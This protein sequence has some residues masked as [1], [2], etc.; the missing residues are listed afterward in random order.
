MT[1][2]SLKTGIIHSDTCGAA[3]PTY[4]EPARALNPNPNNVNFVGEPVFG[5]ESGAR[6]FCD[7]LVKVKKGSKLV[8]VLY[9]SG[10]V[11]TFEAGEDVQ[12]FPDPESEGNKIDV[13]NTIIGSLSRFEITTSDSDFGVGERV[14]VADGLGKRATALVSSVESAVGVVDFEIIGDYKGWGYS[15]DAE[16]IGTD[17]ILQADQ[18]VFENTD[19]FYHTNPFQQFDLA[20]QDLITLRI[21]TANTSLDDI[22]LLDELTIHNNDDQNQNVVFTC[23]VVE[24]KVVDDLLICNYT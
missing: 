7:K 20:K 24:K 13:K 1:G 16:V 5:V 18:L 21:E 8:D 11:G 9:L 15:A 14:Y 10:L 12:C 4:C 2:I 3:C 17:R 22:D 23:T 19:Y 6:A